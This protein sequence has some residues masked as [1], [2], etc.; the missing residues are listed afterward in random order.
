MMP[1]GTS[2]KGL[3][4]ENLLTP[5]LIITDSFQQFIPTE[6]G[7]R[8][9]EKLRGEAFWLAFGT[10]PGASEKGHPQTVF[11]LPLITLKVL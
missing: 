11:S 2:D 6:A 7:D 5:T 9:R 8:G 3:M 1:S 10:T 4:F